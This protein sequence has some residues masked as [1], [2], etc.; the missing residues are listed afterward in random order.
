MDGELLV[1]EKGE[2]SDKVMKFAI[3]CPQDV[4]VAVEDQEK[5]IRTVSKFWHKSF[6]LIFGCNIEIPLR[7]C[8]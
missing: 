5:R 3:I 8:P 2:G 6:S 4:Q 7:Q 1:L